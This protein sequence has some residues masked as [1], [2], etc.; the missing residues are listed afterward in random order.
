MLFSMD[1]SKGVIFSLV[2]HPI[3]RRKNPLLLILAVVEDEKKD[4]DQ[5]E[6]R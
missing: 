1:P 5:D 6:K 3:L 4:R 2:G